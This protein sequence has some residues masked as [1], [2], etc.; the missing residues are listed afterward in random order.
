MDLNHLWNKLQE[1]QDWIL[2]K[3]IRC[4]VGEKGGERIVESEWITDEI[5]EGVAERR[6]LKRLERNSQGEE[7]AKWKR[8][9]ETQKAKVQIIVK[10]T[11]RAWEEEMAR[12][13][14]NCGDGGRKLWDLI[15]KMRGKM[16]K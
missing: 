6:R 3:T 2:K 10:T 13:V 15:N 16:G 11:K 7:R 1:V 9:W 14:R 4:R 12:K 5:R 8:E